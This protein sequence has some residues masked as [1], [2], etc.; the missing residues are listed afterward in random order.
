M[1]VTDILDYERRYK[2]EGLEN[3]IIFL[4]YFSSN[5]GN[6]YPLTWI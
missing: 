5:N 1:R 3:K 2:G 4:Y 6:V